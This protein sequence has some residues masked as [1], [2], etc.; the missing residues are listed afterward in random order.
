MKLNDLIGCLHA[1]EIYGEIP[2]REVSCICI[3]SRKAVK[4]C[5]FVALA[6][7]ESDGND[8]ISEAVRFGAIAVVSEKHTDA[9]VPQIIIKNARRALAMLAQCFYDYPS[10]K[11]SLIGVTGT[12]GKTTTSEFLSSILNKSGKKTGVIGTLGAF[13]DGKEYAS[14]LTTPDP[15]YFQYLLNEMVSCGVEY[16]VAE[17]SAHALYYDKEYG[18]KYRACIFTNLTQDH[19]DFFGDMNKYGEA[20][21]KLF[22]ERM[23]DFVVI[24]VDDKFGRK[25][26]EDRGNALTFA[27]ESPSDIFCVVE[28][29]N[30]DGSRILMN[31]CDDLCDM[32]INLTG[33]Y[34]IYNAMG[35]AAC[36]WKMGVDTKTIS[37]GI[38]SVTGVPG[39]LEKAGEYCGGRIYVD[40]AH[41]PDGLFKSIKSLKR[42]CKGKLYC[43][44][45]CGGNRDRSKRKK[46]GEIAASCS[47][48][49]II[50]SDNPRYEDPLS[51]M[52]EIEDG[53]PC[54]YPYVCI[55]NREEA[56]VY[57]ISLLQK[58]DI[59][60]I[61]GKGA[62]RYQEIMGIKYDY[63]DYNVIKKV[64][65]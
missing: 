38:S 56:I 63:S 10:K 3:D 37:E 2:D 44:F 24:N 36:A 34:N 20:K 29:E 8:F 33:E 61:A 12:N 43:L 47:D 41:T 4:G 18:V 26:A 32:R 28:E 30:I 42:Y 14:D 64:I 50:T 45:G 46:M 16:C 11:I 22:N 40:F 48:G 17:I 39:R 59:L 49:V 1:E 6:G 13:F 19:L 31:L 15:V 60:L 52:K 53:M 7:G 9:S 55:E 21:K 35:A 25:L 23:S 65:G 54:D 57:A 62:E 58:D 27:L 5:L 51:I